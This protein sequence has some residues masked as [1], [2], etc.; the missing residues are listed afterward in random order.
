MR[1]YMRNICFA[2]VLLLLLPVLFS[3]SSKMSDEEAVT[4]LSE[5]IPRSY[6]MNRVFWGNEIQ[7]EDAEA[8]P[9]STVT[10]AQYYPVDP[11]GKY[12]TIDAIKAEAET[13]FTAEYLATVY[14]MAFEGTEDFEPRFK[15]ENGRLCM[16]ITY[17]PYDFTTEIDIES[18]HVIKTGMGTVQAELNCTTNGKQGKMTVTI[19]EN[20]G[21]WYLDSPTY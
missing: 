11:N 5:L 6:E 7:L 21:Q 3:C 1:R 19:C 2:A 12:T 8:E 15:E 4:I 18:A 10:A 16:D 13:I 9:L 14:A 20:D 17:Q